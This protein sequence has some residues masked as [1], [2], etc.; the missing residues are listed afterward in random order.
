[1]ALGSSPRAV[2]QLVLGEGL[3]LTG[4]GLVLG[5][6]GAVAVARNLADQVFGITP[7]DPFVLGAVALV[8]GAIALLASV[9]P[10]RRAARVDPLVVLNDS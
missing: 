10:A 6:A 3:W 4:I 5:L 9:S 1:M 2:F 7:T 8:T